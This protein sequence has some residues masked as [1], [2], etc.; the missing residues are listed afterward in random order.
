MGQKF[1]DDDIVIHRTSALIFL[2]C[3]AQLL[4]TLLLIT[5]T[6]ISIGFYE[7]FAIEMPCSKPNLLCLGH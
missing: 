5:P 2:Q 1:V 6:Y 3:Q 4:D 7:L